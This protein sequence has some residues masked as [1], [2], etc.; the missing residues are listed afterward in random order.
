MD[1]PVEVRGAPAEPL[2]P[3]GAPDLGSAVHPGQSNQQQPKWGAGSGPT[4]WGRLS[5]ANWVLRTRR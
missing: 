3:S 4:G 5:G 2:V 1:A